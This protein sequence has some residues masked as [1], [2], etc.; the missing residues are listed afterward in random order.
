MLHLFVIIMQFKEFAGL[1]KSVNTQ[2]YT[3]IELS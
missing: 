3:G 1:C 2:I